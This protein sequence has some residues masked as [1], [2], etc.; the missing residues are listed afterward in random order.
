MFPLFGILHRMIFWELARVFLL[1]LSGL[2]GLFLIAGLVQ[3]AAQLGLSPMQVLGVI[4]LL[5]P[6]TLPYTIPATTLF[7]SC[8]VY[9]R[10][11]T[12]NEAVAMKAAGV[13]LYTILKP[14]VLLGVLSTAV[15]GGLYYSTIPRTQTMLQE[16]LLQ[17]PEEVLYN[18]LKRERCYRA[19][20]FPYV[21][22][23]R[24]VQGKRLLDVVMKRRAKVKTPDGNEVWFGYDFVARAQEARL[25]VDLE[26]NTLALDPNRWA[27]WSKDAYSVVDGAKPLQIPLPDMF[28]T[29]NAKARPMALEWDELPGRI[30]ELEDK[31][32]KLIEKRD[33]NRQI[34]EATAD[35][36]LRKTLSD[37][38]PHFEAQADEVTRQ[39]RSIQFEQYMR[40]ALACGCLCF[41]V[42]G[43]PV[44]LWAS[45]AD[46]L[47]T[48]VTCFLPTM[49]V[50]YP[51]LLAGGGLARDGKL[52]MAVGV[53]AANGVAG[54]A[55]LLLS[56]RLIRR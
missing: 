5:I 15:T 11:S 31:R 12:D 6:S 4:P 44:G 23:V 38:E 51:L 10:V 18:L 13:N 39:V 33:G 41:A 2:T 30:D 26:H 28:S 52:P 42:I 16:Q 3:Q 54:A 46:Y 50:Y 45:R 7:A 48:F 37:Q 17:D 14:A 29:K 34:A 27:I 8:V 47:S 40:P 1:S 32:A 49:F 24:D 9:G 36:V 19:T 25:I 43:C 21:I 20:N 22:Y 35:P 56:W 55:A 53:W